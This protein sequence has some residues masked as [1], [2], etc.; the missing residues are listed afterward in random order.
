MEQSQLEEVM[1]YHVKNLSGTS[2]EV[3]VD[4]I[5]SNYLQPAARGKRNRRRVYSDCIGF[6]ISNAVHTEK[7]WT[8][9]WINLTI[10]QLAEKLMIFL[11]IFLLP[12][13]SQAQ[14]QITVGAGKSELRDNIVTIGITYLK[15]FDSIWKNSNYRKDGKNS[16]FSISPEFNMLTGTDDAFSSINLKAVGHLMTFKTTEVAGLKTPNTNALFHTFPF[17][18]GIETNNNFNNINAILEAGWVPWYQAPGVNLPEILKATTI[19]VFLQAGYKFDIDSTGKPPV[20]GEINQSEERP[21]K[22]LAR[23]K[24][25]IDVD[26]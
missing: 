26:T 6:T 8:S 23:V 12:L 14:V 11:L 15:S 17:A 2:D 24:G 3:T 21:D 19:G 1:I 13:I 18:V 16:I 9:E 7:Q 25:S 22:F 5:H 4:S 10:R 20:G